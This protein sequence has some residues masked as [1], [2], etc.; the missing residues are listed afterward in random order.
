[1][2]AALDLCKFVCGARLADA[3]IT[4]DQG[5]TEVSEEGVDFPRAEELSGAV[6]ALRV[7]NGAGGT[8]LKRKIPESKRKRASINA[9]VTRGTL[10]SRNAKTRSPSDFSS[11]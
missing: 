5:P 7:A 3:V 8:P 2:G 1:M 4:G 11:T 6:R 10:N 9:K